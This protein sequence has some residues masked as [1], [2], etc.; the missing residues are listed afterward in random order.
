MLVVPPASSG[1]ATQEPP[2]RRGRRS[3][4]SP[5]RSATFRFVAPPR[6]HLLRKPAARALLKALRPDNLNT[7]T[8]NTKAGNTKTRGGATP[9]SWETRTIRAGDHTLARRTAEKRPPAHGEMEHLHDISGGIF[10]DGP[11]PG[12]A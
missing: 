1:A 6:F 8:C 11:D 7:K 4:P 5:I 12:R 3:L 2:T 9:L 10:A